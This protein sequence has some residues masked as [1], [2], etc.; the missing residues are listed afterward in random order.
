MSKFRELGIISLGNCFYVR[1]ARKNGRDRTGGVTVVSHWGQGRP[2]H[3]RSGHCRE[4]RTEESK[5]RD[6]GLLCAQ[7]PGAG[8]GGDGAG[9]AL[10]G[11]RRAPH[12]GPGA[13]RPGAGGDPL[14]PG[15]HDLQLEPALP[16][17]YAPPEKRRPA[18]GGPGCE[19]PGA[20][21]GGA[22]A[23][24]RGTENAPLCQADSDF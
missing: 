21:G 22:R 17:E 14:P 10:R 4:Y 6:P 15:G 9:G 23:V 12:C 3:A 19:G 1:R 13:G 20:S 18:G 2:S 8:H 5:R 11:D 16:G 7:A 24:Y